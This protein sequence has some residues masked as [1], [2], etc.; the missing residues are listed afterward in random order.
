M[1]EERKGD[2]GGKE[3]MRLCTNFIFYVQ[4]LP[5]G[6]S[7]SSNSNILQHGIKNLTWTHRDST[8][9]PFKVVVY[10]GIASTDNYKFRGF[11]FVF[12]PA[13]D[14]NGLG[15]FLF[16]FFLSF[17]FVL[18]QSPA[19]QPGLDQNPQSSCLV[20]ITHIITPGKNFLFRLYSNHVIFS[21]SQISA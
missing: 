21:I 18:N 13:S 9:I 4:E 8:Q 7:N 20:M 16:F 1:G 19:M 3:S 2:L 11:C 15:F 6:H 5:Q 12:I 14:V 10:L 17:D